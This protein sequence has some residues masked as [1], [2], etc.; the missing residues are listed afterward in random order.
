MNIKPFRAYRYDDSKVG[1]P[2]DCAAPPYDVIDDEQRERLYAKNDYNIVR[3]I[4]SKTFDTDTEQDNQYT[5]AAG[6]LN[7][8]LKKGVLKQ[9]SDESIY[10]YLQDFRIAGKNYQRY[11]FIARA[12]LEDFG[13]IVRPHEQILNK[14]RIDRYNLQKATQAVFGLVFM[15]YDDPANTVEKIVER[16]VSGEPLIDMTDEQ[17]VR[18]RIYS[19]NEPDDIEQITAMMNDKSC[20]I[21]DGHHRY[22]T[23]LLFAQES[24]NPAHQYQMMAFCNT[25]HEGLLVLATH[26]LVKNLASFDCEKLCESLAMEFEIEQFDF[27]AE[28]EKSG[29]RAAMLK[30]MKT[31]Y[32]RDKNAFGI[33]CGS[34]KFCVVTLKDKSAM[35]SVAPEKSK[36]WRGLD[37][38]VLHKLI[39]E[40]YLKIDEGKL[41]GGEF[42]EY[43]KD[44]PEAIDKS[45]ER[46]DKG[47]IQAAFFMNSP[48]I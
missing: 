14:P 34:G 28:H 18:H 30:K 8:W 24:N 11:S 41:S 9:D 7:D 4:K 6:F 39:L 10:A 22:T 19:I 38:A 33:Y 1:E 15:L 23:H 35:D 42:V 32:D 27:A 26:R 29:S 46:V 12:K 45:I 44:T 43:V 37:V 17:Q 3:V 2:A 31:E 13:K 25:C 47:S 21:A 20:V 48:R 5:R 16:K 36:A 40:K